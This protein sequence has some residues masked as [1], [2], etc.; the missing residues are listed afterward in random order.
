MPNALSLAFDSVEV[1]VS[2]VSRASGWYQ[3]V[4]GLRQTWTDGA[5]V[6]FLTGGD[7]QGSKFCLVKTHEPARL[8]IRNAVTGVMH[9]VI[10]LNTV[11]VDRAHQ[12]IRDRGGTVGDLPTKSEHQGPLPRGFALTDPD[13][14]RIGVCERPAAT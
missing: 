13:G 6:A 8:Q 3:R 10:H 9:S 11:D 12:I 5:S 7:P 4:L 1:P 14:N 2:D